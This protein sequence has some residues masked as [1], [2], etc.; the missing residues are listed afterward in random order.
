MR[1][2]N[3]SD[4]RIKLILESMIIIIEGYNV[5]SKNILK[6]GAGYNQKTLNLFILPK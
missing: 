3:L 6:D 4:K 5:N 1:N 2:D